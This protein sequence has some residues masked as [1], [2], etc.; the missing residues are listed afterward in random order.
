MLGALN[1]REPVQIHVL[2]GAVSYD[3]ARGALI[4]DCSPGSVRVIPGGQL[5]P[6]VRYMPASNTG[7]R[8]GFTSCDWWR[9]T[10]QTATSRRPR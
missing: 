10:S 1:A 5:A 9:R 8:I 4:L 7:A 2:A 6:G 3:T